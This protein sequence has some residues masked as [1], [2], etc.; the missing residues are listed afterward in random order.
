M[1]AFRRCYG[2]LRQRIA[3]AANERNHIL[4]EE[5][6]WK[7]QL[8]AQWTTPDALIND[9]VR[10]A[11]RST[12]ATRSRII[13]GEGN[14][15]WAI[16]TRAGADLI[17]RVSRATTFAAEQW[18]TQQAGRMGVPV[19]EILLVDDAVTIDDQQ[20]AIW[21]HRTIAG[22][23]LGTLQDAATAHRLTADAGELLA[24]IHAVSTSGNGPLDAQGRGQLNNFSAYLAWDDGA[25]D[26]ALANGIS[27]AAVDQ[28]AHLLA[29]YEHVWATPP[30]LLH[31][32][33]LP[34]HVLV[35][36][37]A[38]A[39]I[40]DFGNTRSGDPAYDLAYWQFFWDS[41]R[42]PSA[43]LREGYRRAGDPGP[44]L[45]LR[46]HLCRL[47]LSMRAIAYYTETGRTFPAQHAAQRFREALAGL[48]T[49]V[50]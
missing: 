19:P 15:V 3:L 31:G 1:V 12:V 44:L 10:R 41:D 40:I 23:P 48:R 45:D 34:E 47:G 8:H 29:T 22:Q 5:T 20:I 21:I 2:A 14:E 24:R 32:D 9:L 7:E 11:A 38:V 50:R 18:A 27:R 26:A 43:A 16:T 35:Q 28:A 13:G 36:D 46:E 25:A 4:D 37:D 30:Q 49:W 42:Y 17:L 6:R 39:G 33:W